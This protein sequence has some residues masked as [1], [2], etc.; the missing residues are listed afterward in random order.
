MSLAF[1]KSEIASVIMAMGRKNRF[2]INNRIYVLV[3]E[4]VT[5]IRQVNLLNS[6]KP[7]TILNIKVIFIMN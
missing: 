6:Q 4:P 2:A 3:S 7:A 5:N 1:T